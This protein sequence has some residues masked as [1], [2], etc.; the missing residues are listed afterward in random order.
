MWAGQP[1]Y[2]KKILSNFDMHN[3]KPVASP[4]NPNTKL[5]ACKDSGDVSNQQLYQALVGSLLYFSDAI[6]VLVQCF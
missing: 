1:F 3:S 5:A 4:V 6:I 2:I